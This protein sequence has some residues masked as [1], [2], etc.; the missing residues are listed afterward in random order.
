M[1]VFTRQTIQFNSSHST[2]SMGLDF[3]IQLLLALAGQELLH[4]FRQF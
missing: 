2:D 4:R 1:Q 3:I